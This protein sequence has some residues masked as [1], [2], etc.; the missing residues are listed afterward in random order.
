MLRVEGL[1]LDIYSNTRQWLKDLA[2]HVHTKGFYEPQV[3]NKQ[4]IYLIMLIQK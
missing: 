1:T 4:N 2:K 3:L